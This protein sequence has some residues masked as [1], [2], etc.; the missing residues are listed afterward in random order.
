MTPWYRRKQQIGKGK[1]KLTKAT[2]FAPSVK[3]PAPIVN[4]KSAPLSLASCTISRI[5]DQYVWLRI[6]MRVPTILFFP[7]EVFRRS[8]TSVF[9]DREL[10]QIM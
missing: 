1:Y 4:I 9:R 10:E 3:L 2:T 8:S 7:M 5:S 6:P